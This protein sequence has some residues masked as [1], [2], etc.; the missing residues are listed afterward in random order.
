MTISLDTDTRTANGLSGQAVKLWEHPSPKS[1]HLWQFVERLNKTYNLQ[2]KSYEEAHSWSTNNIAKLWGEVWQYCGI[3]A[4]QQYTEVVDEMAP[5]FPRPSFFQGAR[6]NF[7]ENL[8]YPTQHVDPNSPA[9]IAAT[10]TT[11]ETVSW[12]ELQERVRQCQAGMIALDLKEGDRVAGYVANHT[13]AL[14]AMLAATSLG[15]IWTAVSPDTGVT[16]VLDR[17]QQIE[18]ALLFTDN[19]AFYNGRSHPVMDKLVD[20]VAALPTLQ[21]VVMLQT[22][23]TVDIDTSTIKMSSGKAYDYASFVALGDQNSAMIFAQLPAD[24]P[25]YILYSSGTTG[26]PKCIVHG[27]IGTLMQH[28][29]EHILHCDIRSGDRLFYFTTCTWMM[30]HWLVSGLA[31]GATLVLYDGS[32]FRSVSPDDPLTSVPD[33]LAMPRLIDELGI[34]HFGTSAKYLSVLEQKGCK[35]LNELGLET[36]QAIYS[37]G[38]PLAPSTFQYVYDAFPKRINLGSITG[39]TDI[40]SL[41]GAPNPLLPVHAGEIQCLGLGMACAAYDYA[42]ND[43]TST[44]EAGD[45]VCTKPFPCQPVAFWGKEGAKKYRSSY[46]E[47]FKGVWHHG[48]FVRFNPET[49]GLV[50]LGRSDGILKPAGVRFGSAEIYNVL[51]K[52]FADKV[53]DALCIGRRRENIDADETVCLFL[54][55]AEGKEFSEQL[56]DRIKKTI[57]EELSARHVPG[58]V[59]ECP[60]IPVTT[61]GK[62]VEGAVKQI[63]CGLNV[64]TSA[65]VANADCLDWYRDWAK[66]HA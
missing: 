27:A 43:I 25:V 42:G 45:L 12:A 60:E 50:M 22:V 54:K 65:S 11:R 59:E 31:S 51:L 21:A 24:H 26:A 53:A 7:A 3:R 5:I 46:F 18:P 64:K 20:I 34:T 28:K 66:A 9:V 37:T 14:V 2:L 32:P 23:Q 35:P 19:A 49:K 39:G 8:L 33:D 13:N 15:C 36:L 16:A 40:I 38:S 61:N 41:F 30:W 52:H 62:K 29:K 4:S 6:L 57:K 48:D 10:E 63:L 1:T 17:M 55:M 56:A 44:G 47:K 58:I